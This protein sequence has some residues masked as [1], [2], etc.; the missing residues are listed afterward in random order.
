[1][2]P[3][4]IPTVFCKTIAS[5]FSTTPLVLVD[6]LLRS[7]CYGVGL[8]GL[9][10][11]ASCLE[12]HRSVR[13]GNAES[14]GRNSSDRPMLKWMKAAECEYSSEMEVITEMIL[15]LVLLV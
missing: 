13:R 2:T 12:D 1:M 11:V 4:P 8:H 10:F 9:V 15:K 14:I 3:Q 7:N 6:L 5:C